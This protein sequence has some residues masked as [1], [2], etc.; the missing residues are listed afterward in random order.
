MR[1]LKIILPPLVAFAIFAILIS[2]NPLDF[3][4]SGLGDIGDGSRSGLIAY[5][6]I[7][8]PLQFI[9][10]IL[11]QHLI[12]LPLWDRILRRHQIAFTV[13]TCIS[14]VCLL[15]ASTIGYIIWDRAAGTE[16]LIKIVI[17]MTGVQI[18]YWAINFLTLVAMDWAKLQRSKKS[19]AEST[20]SESEE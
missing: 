18:I 6:K 1:F 9:I 7:F 4:I 16:R 14:I 2:Y 11:T 13:F 19:E 17:F 12:I 5:F 3:S 8:A 10:A 15:A 20:K